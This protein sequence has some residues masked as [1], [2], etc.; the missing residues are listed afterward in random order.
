MKLRVPGLT[1]WVLVGLPTVEPLAQ[2][3][4][5]V[6]DLAWCPGSKTCLAWS[7]LAEA[8]AYNVHRGSGG[9]LPQL[10]DRSTDSCHVG[11]Y[12]VPTTG[13]SLGET[14]PSGQLRWYLVTGLNA[15]GEGSAGAGTA[16]E[17]LLDSSG[18]CAALQ[19]L[20][21][22]EVDYDQDGTDSGEF[23]EIHNPG[24][25]RSLEGVVLILVNGLNSTEY[26]RIALDRAGAT[27]ATG[28]L[29]VV[30]TSQVLAGLPPATPAVAF[31]AASN[32]VQNGSPDG[33]ALFDTTA[34]RVLDALSYEGSITAAQL[35][36]IPGQWNLVEGNPASAAD[37]ASI[38]GS[39]VR[40]PD[41]AD[42]DDA[43]ADWSFVEEPSPGSANPVP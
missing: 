38:T 40:S 6:L 2:V 13:S 16:G 31:A 37:S 33:L 28:G 29:L 21:I 19:D 12:P 18:P 30:G 25:P 42:T 22:N 34:V 39:L 5:E 26:A 32:N 27:L 41:G 7:A 43:D 3:P 36:G 10:L 35:D 23:V 1:L 15:F 24:P 20:V 9:D 8:S 17:R 14:I 4:G 11:A